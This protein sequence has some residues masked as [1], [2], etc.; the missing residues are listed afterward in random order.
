VRPAASARR[1]GRAPPAVLPLPFPLLSVPAVVSW[2]RRHDTG[3][4]HRWLRGVIAEIIAAR[5]AP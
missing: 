4:A 3:P 1:P 5:L 2:H